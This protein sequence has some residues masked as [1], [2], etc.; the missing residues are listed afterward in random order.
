[1][2]TLSIHVMMCVVMRLLLGTTNTGK[3]I[4]IREAL[5]ALPLTLLTPADVK[6]SGSPH[7]HGTTY[8]ENAEIKSRFFFDAS[9]IPSM[10]DDSGIIVDALSGE[11]GIHTRRWGA[12]P[13]ATDA[14]WIAYFLKRMESE[15][16]RRARFVCAIAYTDANGDT[17]HFEGACDGMITPALE[18]TYLKG[19]PISACFKPDGFDA[20]YSALSVEQKNS[21]S[22]RGRAL[23]SFKDFLHEALRKTA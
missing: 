11:L 2:Q 4:E 14:E 12:G 10:A 9:G 13:E 8:A 22:H 20:V 21:T 1:M 23:R 6:I 15:S 16:N 19:L 3:I 5:H 17:H 18:A 7:E